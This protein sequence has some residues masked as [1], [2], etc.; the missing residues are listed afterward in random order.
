ML[1][2]DVK[3]MTGGMQSTSLCRGRSGISGTDGRVRM[4][5]VIIDIIK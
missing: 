2:D 5:E 1:Q 4:E 3:I